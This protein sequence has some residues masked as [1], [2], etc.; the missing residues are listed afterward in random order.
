MIE[1]ATVNEVTTG[2]SPR[3]AAKRNHQAEQKQQ[4]VRAVQ[5][6]IKAQVEESQRGLMPAGIEPHQPGSPVNSKA[7][8]A[9][10]GGRKRKVVTTR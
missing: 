1:C 8:T 2:T 7:R 3:I 6:V 10:P 5:N 4:V 9:P